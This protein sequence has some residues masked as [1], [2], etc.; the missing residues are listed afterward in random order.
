MT[1]KSTENIFSLLRITNCDSFISK[2][3]KFREEKRLAEQIHLFSAISCN[4][5]N[6]FFHSRKN[7]SLEIRDGRFY[8]IFLLQKVFFKRKNW[9]KKSAQ[10]KSKKGSKIDSRKAKKR[11]ILPTDS[12][13]TYTPMTGDYKTIHLTSN[14]NNVIV[15]FVG[16]S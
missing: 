16:I 12:K 6:D 15:L 13:V 2:S 11:G 9:R 7:K 5:L 4:F 1:Q 14:L 10:M 8:S 3:C